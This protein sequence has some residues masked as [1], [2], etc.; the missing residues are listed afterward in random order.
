MPV[1]RMLKTPCTI[2]RRSVVDDD[3][4][5][6]EAA[7]E[8]FETV[9]SLQQRRRDETDDGDLSTTLWDL[10]LLHGTTF[11]TGDAARV[12]GRF[13]EAVGEPWSAE[14]GSRSMWHVEATV[15]RVAG[16]DDDEDGS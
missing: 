9:C 14:E 8:E 12:N 7:P 15:R 13:F 16:T 1:A 2:I 10:T 3:S 6:Q 11:D 4:F 5:D